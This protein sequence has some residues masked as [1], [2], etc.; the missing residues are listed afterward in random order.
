[1]RERLSTEYPT[2]S[3]MYQCM[4]MAVR[5]EDKI[6]KKKN[7]PGPKHRLGPLL[8]FHPSPQFVAPGVSSLSPLPPLVVVA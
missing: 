1:M 2:L 6:V 5:R 3:G 4:R 8:S 7:I